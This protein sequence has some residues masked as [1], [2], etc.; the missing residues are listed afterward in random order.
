VQSRVLARRRVLDFGTS[1]K[2]LAR[3]RFNLGKKRRLSH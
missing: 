2:A 3:R 1:G